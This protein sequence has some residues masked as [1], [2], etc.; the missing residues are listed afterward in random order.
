MVGFEKGP[1]SLKCP[2][3]GLTSDTA[4]AGHAVVLSTAFIFM[5]K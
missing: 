2:F 5:S 4:I 3:V 1:N